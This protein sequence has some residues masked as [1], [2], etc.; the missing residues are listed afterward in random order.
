MTLRFDSISMITAVGLF[1]TFFAVLLMLTNKKGNLHANI[2]FSLLMIFMSLIVCDSGIIFTSGLYY[3]IPHFVK[4]PTIVA[5]LYGPFFYFYLKLLT[6]GKE[7]LSRYDLLHFIPFFVYLGIFIP[8]L[9]QSGD[10]KIGYISSWL[11]GTISTPELIKEYILFACLI[12]QVAAY[13]VFSLIYIHKVELRLR[14]IQSNE[15]MYFSWIK[16]FIYS[17]LSVMIVIL[18]FFVAVSLFDLPF[19]SSYRVLPV[20]ITVA[21]C[22]LAFRAAKQS[23]IRVITTDTASFWK[24][25]ESTGQLKINIDTVLP[26]ITKAMVERKLF[27]NPE[28][29]LP[30]FAEAVGITRNQLSFILNRH[31]GEN[32]YDFVNRYR[33][34]E[35]KNILSRK[36]TDDIN[37]LHIGLD[38]GFNSKTSFNVN[39]KKLTGMSPSEY[40]KTFS[41]VVGPSVDESC[42]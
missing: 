26:L 21:L 3:Y 16:F 39:F 25:N 4:I 23:D 24:D 13:L 7:S 32:F 41:V 15:K 40:R 36:I 17:F 6:R 30:D 14:M 5:F 8:L 42:A 29:T 12:V 1:L 34:E 22:S 28:L 10:Y 19:R 20:I 37:F 2:A 9:S 33:V 35:A 31:F 38:V 27:M 18:I 11:Y